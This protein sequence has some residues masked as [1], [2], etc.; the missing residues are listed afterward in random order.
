M[1]FIKKTILL[2]TIIGTIKSVS[3]STN[4]IVPD[5]S[6]IYNIKIN[7]SSELKD[8]GFFSVD[9]EGNENLVTGNEEQYLVSGVSTSRLNELKKYTVSEDFNQQYLTH[10][11]GRTDGVDYVNS[12]L[13]QEITYYVD[14]IKYT[15]TVVDSNT[16]ITTFSFLTIGSFSSQFITAPLIKNPTHENIVS[17]PKIKNDVFIIRQGISAFDNNYKLE[18]ITNL[19]EL[20]TYAGGNFFNIINNK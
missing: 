7:L 10:T 1:E 13:N 9:V 12:V 17:Y 14:G 11:T 19:F 6:A 20:E 18:H 4:V 15:D 5:V 16:T 2:K 8:L 3:G